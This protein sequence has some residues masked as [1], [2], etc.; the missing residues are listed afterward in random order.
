MANVTVKDFRDVPITLGLNEYATIIPNAAISTNSEAITGSADFSA[1][2]NDGMIFSN[3]VAIRL[4]GAYTTIM[5]SGTI[6]GRDSAGAI[7]LGSSS[8]LTQ[9]SVINHGD[10]QGGEPGADGIVIQSGGNSIVNTGNIVGRGDSAIEIGSGFESG[11]HENYILNTGLLSVGENEAI[12]SNAIAVDLAGDRDTLINRGTIHGDVDMGAGNDTFDGRGGS[13]VDGTV[14]GAIGDDTY[15]VDDASLAIFEGFGQGADIVRSYVDFA[16]PDNVEELFL[17][18]SEDLNGAGNGDK[19]NL[20]GND[21]RNLLDGAGS[22]DVLFGY[23]GNDTLDGGRGDDYVNGGAGDDILLGRAGVDILEG[24][25]DD[26]FLFGGVDGDELYGGDGN[27]TMKG[28]LGRDTMDGGAGQD[29]FVFTRV[30]DSPSG[31]GSDRIDN[32]VTG[33]DVLDFTGLVSGTLEVSIL[34]AYSGTAPGLRT[35]ENTSGDTIV[36]VDADGDGST[37]MRIAIDGVTGLTESDFLV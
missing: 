30:S 31:G 26:D 24:G 14:F 36:W 4:T 3:D 17:E 5:N 28:G 16:L 2:T 11:Q 6:T 27:D 37:D 10:I 22:L 21:G 19:N 29:V 32:F 8:T 7:R 35:S 15:I 33:E 12:V 20:Y 18:G 34:G 1:V 9:A 25:E 13:V 23:G